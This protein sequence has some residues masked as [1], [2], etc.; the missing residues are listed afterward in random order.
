MKRIPSHFLGLLT[1]FLIIILLSPNAYPQERC[2][3]WAGKVVSIQGTVQVRMSGE[4][5]WQSAKLNDTYCPGD[6][7]RVLIEAGQTSP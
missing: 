7:I 3:Q 6:T 1:F 4:T 5:Q 2:K